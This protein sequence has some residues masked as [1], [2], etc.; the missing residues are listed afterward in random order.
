MDLLRRDIVG[1]NLNPKKGDEVGKVRPCII[2][3]DDDSNEI[4]DTIIVVP[5][6]THL[7]EDMLPFRMRLKKRENLDK[8][9]DIVLNHIR[10]ISKKRVTSKISKI[11]TDEYKII[12]ETFC[13]IF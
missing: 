10:T 6:S 5:L 3:S 1:I 8:D 13:N 2:L 12:I 4:L 9:S 11:T 7:I